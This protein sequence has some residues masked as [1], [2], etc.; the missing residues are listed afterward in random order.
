LYIVIDLSLVQL[1]TG[2]PR[3]FI[4]KDPND[5]L[6]VES[7]WLTSLWR[8]VHI[9]RLSLIYPSHWL[10]TALH[11]H[12]KVLMEIFLSLKLKRSDLI[13]LNKCCIYLWVIT[14]SD[15][16]SADGLYILPA[17]KMGQA[18]IGRTEN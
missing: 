9:A 1:L 17:A 5:Y 12:D 7:G 8:F 2:I 3:F 15:I 14:L 10:P 16:T 11:A 4:N 6:W 13:F 18:I